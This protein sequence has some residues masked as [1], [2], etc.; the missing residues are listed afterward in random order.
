MMNRRK[1][2]HTL[3]RWGLAIILTGLT[4]LL[5]RKVVLK[6]ECSSCPDYASCP[7][8]NNCEIIESNE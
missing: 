3:T 8:A 5:G 4:L 7:G 6:K 1:F 2:I